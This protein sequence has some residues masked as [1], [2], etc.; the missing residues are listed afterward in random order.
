MRAYIFQKTNIKAGLNHVC[1]AFD[2]SV[3][4]SSKTRYQNFL[5]SRS[6]VVNSSDSATTKKQS[7]FCLYSENIKRIQP[8]ASHQLSVERNSNIKAVLPFNTFVEQ[9]DHLDNGGQEMTIAWYMKHNVADVTFHPNFINELCSFQITQAKNNV[10]IFPTLRISS[11][12]NLPI[13]CVLKVPDLRLLEIRMKRHGTIFVSDTK[14]K[15]L[16]IRTE[17]GNCNLKNVRCEE[18]MSLDAALGSIRLERVTSKNVWIKANRGEVIGNKMKASKSTFATKSSGC[19]ML[20][21]FHF[22][23]AIITVDGRKTKLKSSKKS[24]MSLMKAKGDLRLYHRET[25]YDG[26]H[27]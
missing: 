23:E 24:N 21:S 5:I 1:I 4:I 26:T 16:I 20:N 14:S 11:H 8:F 2:W 22:E 27:F 3:Y 12:F 9:F 18:N 6:L 19:I 10:T 25:K 13:Y 17:N 7:R 15:Y